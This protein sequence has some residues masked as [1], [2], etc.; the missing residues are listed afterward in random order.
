[1]AKASKYRIA[2]FNR[3]YQD[4]DTALKTILDMVYPDG[5]TLPEV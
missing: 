5:V 2:D 3:D 1:M 4:E